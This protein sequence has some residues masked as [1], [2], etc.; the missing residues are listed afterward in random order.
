MLT[1]KGSHPVRRRH[2]RGCDHETALSSLSLGAEPLH[3][4]EISLRFLTPGNRDS[5]SKRQ[6]LQRTPPECGN[7]ALV[8]TRSTATRTSAVFLSET[9][10]S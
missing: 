3:F 5:S 6:F 7:R 1:R 10:A 2:Q 9:V 4:W 8:L